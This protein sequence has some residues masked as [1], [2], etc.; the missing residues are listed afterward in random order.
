LQAFARTNL[1]QLAI[2]GVNTSTSPESLTVA[3]TNLPAVASL[4]LFYTDSETNLCDAGPIGVMNGVFQV[5]VPADSVFTVANTNTTVPSVSVAITSPANRTVYNGPIDIPIQAS[6]SSSTGAI[7]AVIFYCGTNQI[8]QATAPPYGMVWRNVPPGSYALRA[9]ATN[10]TG[11]YAVS[12]V[13]NV[14][15]AGPPFQITVTPGTASIRAGGSVQFAATATDALGTALNPQPI[16]TW[17]VTGGG[18]IIAGLFTATNA[19]GLFTITAASGGLTGT[20][21]VIVEPGNLMAAYGFE[22]GSGNTVTDSSG[23]GNTGVITGGAI[24]TTGRFGGAIYFDG[25]SAAITVNDSASLDLTSGMTL[26][27]WVNPGSI[28]RQNPVIRKGTRS[29]DDYILSASVATRTT[30]AVFCDGF[31]GNVYAPSAIPPD[32]WTYLAATY[33]ETNAVIY[34]NGVL[35]VSTPNFTPINVSASSLN[36]GFAAPAYFLGTIDEVRI[37]NVALNGAQIQADMSS[38]VVPVVTNPPPAAL[39]SV[40]AIGHAIVL[41]WPS[42][43]GNYVLE[44]ATNLAPPIPWSPLTNVPQTN[45]GKL[46]VVVSPAV[47]QHFFRLHQY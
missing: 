33:D 35:A 15:V 40:T 44:S 17:T 28:T 14:S 4:E 25:T 45:G 7:Y 19:G 42:P 18:T 5:T 20:A 12:A 36:I 34:T 26:E 43:L 10:S 13:V 8:G 30:P 37:Y 22:E 29:P 2:V 39:L 47:C 1:G 23:N 9:T 27:A 32:A 6:A 16:L 38:A 46:C 11:V 24:W 21:N 3:L 31:A 41:A